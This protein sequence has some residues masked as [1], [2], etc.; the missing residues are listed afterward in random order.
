M[1]TK[2][3]R[4][5]KYLKIYSLKPPNLG[6]STESKLYHLN[7]KNKNKK[8]PRHIVVNMTKNKDKGRIL[9]ATR[10]KHITCKGISLRLSADFS[11]ETL[12]T[13]REDMVYSRVLYLMR[14]SFRFDEKIKNFKTSKN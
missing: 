1:S 13:R 9:K 7:E 2:K 14:L 12:L 3:R 4:E 6:R 11:A 5:R 10:E 8:T